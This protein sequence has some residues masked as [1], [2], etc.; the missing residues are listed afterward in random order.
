MKNKVLVKLSVPELNLTFDLFIPV[1]EVIWK[2]KKLIIKAVSDLSDGAFDGSIDY[3]L[4][5]QNSG[6]VYL[7]NDVIIDTEIRN[8]SE[9][10]LFSR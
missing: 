10:V 6:R 1:N 3:C 8:S 2:V 9:L 4:M 7:N 5:D